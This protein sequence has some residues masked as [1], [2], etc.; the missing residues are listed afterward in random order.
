MI[1]YK[2]QYEMY[3]PTFTKVLPMSTYSRQH[4]IHI[5]YSIYFML[6]LPCILT[7]TVNRFD[8]EDT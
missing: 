7:Y 6:Y 4:K 5:E 2:T 3:D 8:I 1:R